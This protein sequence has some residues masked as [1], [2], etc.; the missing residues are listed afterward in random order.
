MEQ[1]PVPRQITSFEFKLIGF[2]TLR[3]FIYI[4]VFVLGGVVLWFFPLPFPLYL[5]TKALAI[6]TGLMGLVF[7]LVP[8]NDRPMD[9]FI[10]NLIR[11]LTSPT[12]YTYHKHNSSMDMLSNL[13]FLADPHRVVSHI[14]AREK[15]SRYM[16]ATHPRNQQ[17]IQRSQRMQSVNQALAP[18]ATPLAQTIQKNIPRTTAASLAPMRTLATQPTKTP[19]FFGVV[20]NKKK[21]PL[22]NIMVYMKNT[23]NK[24]VRLLKTNTHGVFATFTKL[25]PGEYFLEP[26]DPNKTYFFDTIKVDLQQTNP[27]QIEI[28]SKEII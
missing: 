16:S 3:Q 23:Q 28:T 9:V 8:I 20:K 19:F 11:R 15:L 25:A 10:K 2:M 17:D 18:R 14:D 24:P 21:T 22:P 4:I 5:L 27:K 7:A 12:Q 13:Y 1:H 26:Q 6:I